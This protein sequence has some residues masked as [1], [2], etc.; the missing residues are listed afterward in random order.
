MA[1]LAP[2]DEATAEWL[3]RPQKGITQLLMNFPKDIKLSRDRR[4]AFA[5]DTAQLLLLL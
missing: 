3:S 5:A 2:Q 1:V 4:I